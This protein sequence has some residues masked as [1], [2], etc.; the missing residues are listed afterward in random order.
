V[1]PRGQ[2]PDSEECS[3]GPP[4]HRQPALRKDP[5]CCYRDLPGAAQQEQERH[6]ERAQRQ[7]GR[8]PLPVHPDRTHH[9]LPGAVPHQAHREGVLHPLFRKDSLILE[10]IDQREKIGKK[11]ERIPHIFKDKEK[12][13]EVLSP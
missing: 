9:R 8:G 11:I 3:Q 10:A 6:R 13:S 2:G 1:V 7:G 12:Y 5:S 4:D